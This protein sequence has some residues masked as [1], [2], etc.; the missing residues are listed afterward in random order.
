MATCDVCGCDCKGSPSG[1][2]DMCEDCYADYLK[3]KN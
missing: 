1:Y 2:R 3:D